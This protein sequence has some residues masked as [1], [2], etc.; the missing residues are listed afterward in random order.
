MVANCSSAAIIQFRRTKRARC[1]QTLRPY[2][3]RFCHGFHFGHL[4]GSRR[5]IDPALFAPR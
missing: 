3:Y 2:R 1:P 4:P 5:F